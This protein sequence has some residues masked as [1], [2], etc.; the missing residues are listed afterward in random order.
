[1][2]SPLKNGTN[3][4]DNGSKIKIL[5]FEL[6]YLSLHKNCILFASNSSRIFVKNPAM[7]AWLNEILLL[8]LSLSSN[9]STHK[10]FGNKNIFL[11]YN[12]Y[13]AKINL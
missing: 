3:F 9:C 8:Y 7:L 10:K 1:M 12:F 2:R 4:L 13:N 5:S 11:Q 6:K